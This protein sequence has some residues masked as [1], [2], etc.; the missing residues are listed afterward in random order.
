MEIDEQF[1][2]QLT[3]L[4]DLKQYT[5]QKTLRFDECFHRGIRGNSAVKQRLQKWC[6]ETRTAAL[7]EATVKK[8]YTGQ[9]PAV[10]KIFPRRASNRG[11]SVQNKASENGI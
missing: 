11:I 9:K 5:V 4:P 7:T 3:L 8:Q 10:F 2:R 1:V 6:L